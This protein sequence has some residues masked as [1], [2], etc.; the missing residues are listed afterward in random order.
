ML[1]PINSSLLPSKAKVF[2]LF[3]YCNAETSSLEL[4]RLDL[5]QDLATR[6]LRALEKISKLLNLS[7]FRF[8]HLEMGRVNGT[9][10][11]KYYFVWIR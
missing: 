10:F 8:S 7:G 4:E 9:Y 3:L 6:F 1:L 5:N 2:L 11:I